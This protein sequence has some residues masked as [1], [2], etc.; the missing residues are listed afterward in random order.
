MKNFKVKIRSLQLQFQNLS[1]RNKILVVITFIIS[2]G[3]ITALIASGAF[4]LLTF[5]TKPETDTQPVEQAFDYSIFTSSGL[6][7]RE[8][9]EYA[10]DIVR[11]VKPAPTEASRF[12]AYVSKGYFLASD[13]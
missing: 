9:I 2:F 3:L 8:W 6:L 1:K 4:F 7:S 13:N 12:Y 5:N 10:M 11:E